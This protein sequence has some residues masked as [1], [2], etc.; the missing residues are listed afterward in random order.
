MSLHPEYPK[1][2]DQ[3]LLNRAVKEAKSYADI[4]KLPYKQFWNGLEF[5]EFQHIFFAE[6]FECQDCYTIHNNWM[7][8]FEAKEYRLKE[9]HLYKFDYDGY[10]S[11][12]NNYY[13]SLDYDEQE[14]TL[15]YYYY[16]LFYFIDRNDKMTLMLGLYLANISNRIVILPR[17]KCYDVKHK[18]TP[19]CSTADTECNFLVHWNIKRFN[20]VFKAKYRESVYII[21]IYIYIIDIFNSSIYFKIS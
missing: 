18:T 15:E 13:L 21:Y 2:N 8:G 7:L 4:K 3:D 20:S 6:Q 11:S 10:Y 1:D 16:L 19:I 14:R 17:F 5:F 12:D 9:L